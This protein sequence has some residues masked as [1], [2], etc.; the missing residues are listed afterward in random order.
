[1]RSA[2]SILRLDRSQHRWKARL[3][4]F[5]ARGWR[6]E[7]CT[8]QPSHGR[9]DISSDGD[10][11]LV[12]GI[13]NCVR[14]ID[15]TTV[16]TTLAGLCDSGIAEHADGTGTAARFNQPFGITISP[17]ESTAAISEFGSNVVRILTLLFG[18]CDNCW[19]S[20][21]SWPHGWH[22]WRCTIRPTFWHRMGPHRIL[23]DRR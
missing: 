16:M 8:I 14:K 19:R 23:L 12:T 22:W 21:R 13:A 20:G 3:F 11:A 18:S 2:R 7:H 9:L 17:D 5:G 6:R 10:F 15:L 1:M 4:R